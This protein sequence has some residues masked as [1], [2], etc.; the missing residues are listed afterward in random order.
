[1]FDIV[2]QNSHTRDMLSHSSPLGLVHHLLNIELLPF[3]CVSTED[4]DLMQLKIVQEGGPRLWTPTF[5]H[6]TI[7]CSPRVTLMH[8]V[9]DAI[10]FGLCFAGQQVPQLLVRLGNCLVVSLLGFLEHLLGLLNLHLAGC[11][12]YARQDGFSRIRGFLEILQRLR[13]FCNSLG[14]YSA[15][16]GQPLLIN[17]LE[18]R[19]NVREVFLVVH[20]RVDGHA[21]V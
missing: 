9:A 3:G 12:I 1:M 8:L 13:P 5:G 17:D 15:L 19:N 14:K 18:D 10:P 11:N 20:M 6:L 2:I 7:H 4:C 16:L 21:E